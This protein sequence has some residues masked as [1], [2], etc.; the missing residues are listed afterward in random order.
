MSLRSLC[1]AAAKAKEP[2]EAYSGA[3]NVSPGLWVHQIAKNGLTLQLTLQGT[4]YSKDGDL[5]RK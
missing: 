4:K 1:A 3:A 2:G 5:N